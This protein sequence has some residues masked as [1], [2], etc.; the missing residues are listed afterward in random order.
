MI[1][2]NREIVNGWEIIE[3][4]AN[5]GMHI[6]RMIVDGVEVERLHSGS[7]RYLSA[8][9]DGQYK[10]YFNKFTTGKWKH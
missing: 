8:I 7:L 2:L 4:G 3:K 9:A 6:L 1:M 5:N 10:L